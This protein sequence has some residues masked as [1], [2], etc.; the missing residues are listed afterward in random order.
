V[1]VLLVAS[2]Q[3]QFL[4]TAVPS[5]G[6]C[7]LA[8]MVGDEL[9]LLSI[10]RR[11]HNCLWLR[12]LRPVDARHSAGGEVTEGPV[13]A[14]GKGGAASSPAKVMARSRL[15]RPLIESPYCKDC[16]TA[17]DRDVFDCGA[18]AGGPPPSS[19]RSSAH[20]QEILYLW[21]RWKNAAA[22][23]LWGPAGSREG[24]GLVFDRARERGRGRLKNVG[25]VGR[26]GRCR[27]R[28]RAV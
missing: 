18:D 21:S 8:S 23:C 22:N 4:L 19:M 24:F 5:S 6:I 3:R 25:D 13:N 20:S 9:D 14:I 11:S 2:P 17:G 1:T 7:K 16:C 28:S 26:G 27:P 10:S 15:L 12:S